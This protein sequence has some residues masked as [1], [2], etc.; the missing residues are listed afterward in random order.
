M[1]SIK[2]SGFGQ[3]I[4]GAVTAALVAGSAAAG[5][6]IMFTH[7]GDGAMSGTLDGVAFDSTSIVISGM[8]DIDDR[9]SFGSGFFIEHQSTEISISGLG[10][11]DILTPVGTFVNNNNQI[12][13]FSRSNNGNVDLDLFN[14]PVN[15]EFGSW[16]M[17]TSIGPHSGSGNLLQWDADP[18]IQTSGGI[19]TFNSMTVDATFPATVLPAPGAV[20]LLGVAGLITRRRRRA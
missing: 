11:F 17:T 3:M 4:V 9:T 1:M 20:V 14:G 8:G 5:P 12:V 19:L 7:E 16:D 6:A 10:T 2:L 15:A 13:G 18:Q